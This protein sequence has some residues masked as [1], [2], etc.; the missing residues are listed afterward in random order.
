MEV[1]FCLQS[2]YLSTNV[3]MNTGQMDGWTEKRVTGHLDWQMHVRVYN[4]MDRWMG[5]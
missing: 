5:E 3:S 2:T 1:L 4:W